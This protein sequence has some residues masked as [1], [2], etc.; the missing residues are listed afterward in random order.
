MATAKSMLD[1][2][3]REHQQRAEDAVADMVDRSSRVTSEVL[4]TEGSLASLWLE[5]THAQV[6]HN[7]EA[8]QELMACRDWRAAANVQQAFIQASMNRLGETISRQIE[9]TGKLTTRLLARDDTAVA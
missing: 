1:Q 6:T 8:M 2:P 4:E 7:I 9:L 3:V 5:L